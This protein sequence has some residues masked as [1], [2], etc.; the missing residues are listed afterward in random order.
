MLD[1]PPIRE[2]TPELSKRF[3]PTRFF[4]ALPFSPCPK[5]LPRDKLRPASFWR[6]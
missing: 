4:D 2:H 1:V 5:K 3:R 6:G